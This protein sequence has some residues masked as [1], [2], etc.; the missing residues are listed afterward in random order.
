MD[1][2]IVRGDITSQDTDAIVNA[3]NEQLQPG[4]GVDGAITRAAGP[5]A[6]AD[7][8]RLRE[9]SGV[10]PLPTGSARAGA[11]GDLAAR[12][13][14]YTAGPIYSGAPSD[15]E[16]LQKCHDA[17]MQ[18]A[19]EIGARSLAFPAISCGIYGY[20]VDE[21]APAAI[22]AVMGAKTAV[23]LVR[24]VLFDAR[25]EEAFRRALANGLGEG[26]W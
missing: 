4:G 8:D 1:L 2:E 20:P 22:D 23:E 13:I 17:S 16:L 25:T 5:A 24:F 21:A 15:A 12:W 14:I 11:G 9:G 10:P 18:V 26:R 19:D 3:A 7:R 6:L